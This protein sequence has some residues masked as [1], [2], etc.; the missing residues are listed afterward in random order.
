MLKKER[1]SF[2]LH[3]VNLHNKVLSVDLSQ[4]MSVSEDTIR[5]D[6]NEMAKQGKLIKA[7]GGALSK[8]FHLSIASDHVYALDSK[9]RIATKACKLIKDGMFILTSGG[10][11]IIELAKSLPPE[12]TATFITV[13][14]PAA[15][16]YI[17]HP[18]IE[19]IFIGDKISKNSQIAIGGSVVSRIKSIRADLCFLGTNAID[20]NNGLTD[21]DWE[22]VEVKKAMLESSDRVASL[23]ISE[24]LNTAQR[25]KVCEIS[26]IH[27]LVTELNPEEE[28][29]QPYAAAGLTVI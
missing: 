28:V 11:T 4:Q 25:I 22:V 29:L 21:N 18:N 8:S 15:Y 9:K 12:L 7:H 3:Q 14:V 6:L 24:K 1:Q 16:E 17:H 13:S 27:T 20:I 2:I 19:V 5:R 10:T 26:G 23:A